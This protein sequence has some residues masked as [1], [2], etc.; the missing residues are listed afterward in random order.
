M[1]D[2][3][4][5]IPSIVRD[6]S[7]DAAVP[8]R[9]SLAAL[10]ASAATSIVA[11][12]ALP[13]RVQIRWALGPGPYTGPEFAPKLLV[14]ALF[15]AL[16]AAIAAGAYWLGNSLDRPETSGSRRTYRLAVLGTLVVVVGAQALVVL[17]NVA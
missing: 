15:P 1:T 8:V 7:A 14:V 4:F 10:V 12:G 5:E 2:T 6:S 9:S 11:F 16:V 3:G 13:D 17:A